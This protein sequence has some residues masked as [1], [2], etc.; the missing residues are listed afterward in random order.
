[1]T[2][3]SV[4]VAGAA[5]LLATGVVV[6]VAWVGTIST[7][8]NEAVGSDGSGPTFGRD[9]AGFEVAGQRVM[10]SEASDLYLIGSQS[11]DN[12]T[13]P[14]R[15][16]NPPFYAL[17]MVPLSLHGFIPD[18]LIWTMLGA[19]G[20][21]A[22]YVLLGVRHPL[23]WFTATFFTTAGLLTVFYGQNSFFTFLFLSASYASLRRRREILGGA[24]IGVVAY[25]PQLLGGFLIWFLARYRSMWRAMVGVALSD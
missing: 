20:L 10:R 4:I 6:A 3:R 19:V 14:A 11:T 17:H 22:G 1:M 25:K 18:Y 13:G 2:D 15:F 8:I 24:L 21:A 16:R 5:I 23:A 7:A 12:K 9:F